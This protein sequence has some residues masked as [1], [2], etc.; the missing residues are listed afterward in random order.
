MPF[1][2]IQKSCTP[3]WAKAEGAMCSVHSK[4][5][6]TM[7]LYTTTARASICAECFLAI[8]V[9]HFGSLTIWVRRWVP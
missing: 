2:H 9:L 8:A 7:T 1:L 5:D 3:G 4:K 6:S